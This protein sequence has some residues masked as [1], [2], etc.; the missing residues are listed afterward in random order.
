MLNDEFFRVI[1]VRKGEER[2]SFRIDF[3][4][5]H[6]EEITEI[7]SD[8]SDLID[9]VS[10]QFARLSDEWTNTAIGFFEVVPMISEI[11]TFVADHQMD[12]DF[13]KFVQELAVDKTVSEEGEETK[14]VYSIHLREAARVT[15]KMAEGTSILD[16]ALVIKRSALTALL[17]EYEALMLE[18]I[19]LV[20]KV[21]PEA[22]LG[23]ELTIKSSDF[24]DFDTLEEL[25]EEFVSKKVEDFLHGESHQEILKKIGDKF[26]VNLLSN[27]KL[28][29]EFVEV[30]QR[31]HLISHAGSRANKRYVRICRD[32]GCDEDKMLDLNE[33]VSITRKYLRRAT[34]RVYQ[35]G[36][37]TLHL[38]WQKLLQKPSESDAEIVS[39]S[40][41]FLERDLTKMARRVADFSLSRKSRP[42]DRSYGY[43]LINK[44]QS[45]K[46]DK[47]LDGAAAQ[48][49][50]EGVLS[51]R[52]WSD[53][54]EVNHLA[55]ACL[56]DEYEG[57]APKVVA[58]ARQTNRPLLYSDVFTWNIFREARD[59]DEFIK[60][61]EEAFSVQLKLADDKKKLLESPAGGEGRLN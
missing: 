13:L 25:K 32:A 22:F 45:Y 15:K 50:V 38:L 4:D 55:L 57:I 7:E 5:H 54:S 19:S 10:L 52:D 35:V 42:N 28:I 37:F 34:A 51:K 9:E 24:G 2:T 29:S 48:S 6:S 21:R 23:G 49:K 39:A 18:L 3:D 56:R 46:F 53:T 41:D 33:P 27:E 20:A 60:G 59:N 61:V 14:E 12:N 47:C 8:Q 58:A 11:G 40:H 1:L 16:T 43:L 31:R 30:C 36:F 17:A 44:A 26:N